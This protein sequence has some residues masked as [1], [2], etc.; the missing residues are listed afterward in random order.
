MGIEGG[1]LRDGRG[2]FTRHRV[3]GREEEA[4]CSHTTP[5]AYK[6]V[7]RREETKGQREYKLGFEP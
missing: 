3:S 5:S 2:V 7:N 4:P 1:R 6:T